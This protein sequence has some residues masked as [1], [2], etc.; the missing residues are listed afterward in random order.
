MLN[1]IRDVLQKNDE[2]SKNKEIKEQIAKLEML[3]TQ[4]ISVS[5]SKEKYLVVHILN[6]SPYNH[7]LIK[8]IEAHL[9]ESSDVKH[10]FY[11]Y[12]TKSLKYLDDRQYQHPLIKLSSFTQE[13]I[14]DLQENADMILLQYLYPY[15]MDLFSQIKTKGILAWRPWGGDYMGYGLSDFFDHFDIEYCHQHDVIFNHESR[16]WDDNDKIKFEKFLNHV[17]IIFGNIE[18]IKILQKKYTHMVWIDYIFPQNYEKEDYI[19]P[20]QDEY[21]VVYEMILEQ[22]AS[23]DCIKIVL[24]N[25][26]TP[27][28]NHFSALN[29]L[30]E[31]EIKSNK[32]FFITIMFS[33]GKTTPEYK[34]LLTNYASSLFG[35]RYFIFEQ[36]LKPNDFLNFIKLQD[37]AY[38]NHIRSQG[39]GTINLYLLHNVDVFM[40]ADNISYTLFKYLEKNTNQNLECLYRTSEFLQMII[41]FEKKPKFFNQKNSNIFENFFNQS[42]NQLISILC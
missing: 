32:T 39:F 12:T 35:D 2:I 41:N 18:M 10:K 13:F 20:I 3:I 9:T 16:V 40:R 14:L 17:S 36:F 19:L 23:Q 22:L 11:I 26:C 21:L 28:N 8:M 37:I 42:S 24:G 4:R 38:M 29:M 6:D 30:K 5:P 34:E 15:W 7:S 33:Y 31:V 25:S 1:K 27:E